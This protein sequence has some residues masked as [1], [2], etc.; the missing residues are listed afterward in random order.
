MDEFI[1]LGRFLRT[2]YQDFLTMPTYVRK[3]LVEKII[4]YNTP[5]S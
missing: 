5:T 4:E 2:Q 3:Y 1:L